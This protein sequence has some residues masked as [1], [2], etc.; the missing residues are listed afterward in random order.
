VPVG[1]CG[2]E[3]FI[4]DVFKLCKFVLSLLFSFLSMDSSF[5]KALKWGKAFQVSLLKAGNSCGGPEYSTG[6]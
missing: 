5:L 3:G 4:T 6:I 2:Q 1:V